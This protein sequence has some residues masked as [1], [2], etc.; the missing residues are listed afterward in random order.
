[1][2]PTPMADHS[3]PERIR[4]VFRCG[5]QYKRALAAAAAK[6][7]VSV[8]SY[9]RSCVGQVVAGPQGHGLSDEDRLTLLL[10]QAAPR[11]FSSKLNAKAMAGQ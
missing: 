4:Q 6:S 1:M 5:P 9:L 10:E 7:G 3:D 2:H 8:S 11:S